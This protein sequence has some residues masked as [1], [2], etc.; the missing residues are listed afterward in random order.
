MILQALA[1]HY[2]RLVALGEGDA[3]GTAPRVAPFG[4][5]LQKVSFAVVVRPDGSL[6]QIESRM[7]ESGGGGKSKGKPRPS[8]RIVPGQAKP[9]GSGLNP[10]FLWD[11]PAYLLGVP[12]DP[13]DA[14][15]AARAADGF[16][17]L[18][19]RHLALE[20]AIGDDAFSAVCRFLRAWSPSDAAGAPGRENLDGPGFGVFRL[21]GERRDVHER[22]AVRAYWKSTLTADGDAA[23]GDDGPSVGTCLITGERAKLARLHEPKIKGVLG[24]QSSGGAIVS[25]NDNAYES[26]GHEQGLN[27]PTSEAAAFAYCTALNALLADERSRIRLGDTTCVA[28]SDAPEEKLTPIASGLMNDFVFAQDKSGY[29]DDSPTAEQ[30]RKAVTGFLH[31]LRQGL[32][33]DRAAELEDSGHRFYL[34]GLAPNAARISVRFFHRSTAGAFAENLAD[35]AQNLEMVG[36][37]DDDRPLTVQAMLRETVRDAKDVQPRLEGDV[38]RAVV[39]GLPY[40][41]TLLTRLLS[42]I[43]LDGDVSPDRA[44]ILRAFLLRNTTEIMDVYLNRLHPSRAYHCG[45]QFAVL[46]FAQERALPNVKAGVVKR[47]FAAAMARP[48]LTLGRLQR[49]TEVAHFPKLKGDLEQFARDELQAISGRLGDGPP[50]IL[51]FEDQ[52][53]FAL[54]YYQQRAHLDA[55]GAQVAQQRRYRSVQGEWMRSRLETKV[56]ADLVRFGVPYVYEPSALLDGMGERWPDFLLPGPTPEDCVY[57]E[58]AGYPGEAYD[59]RH[60]AKVAAY[61]R[62]GI[63]PDG[64]PNGR[65][66]VI[67]VRDDNSRYDS[68]LFRRHLGFLL[69][70]AAAA[71]PTDETPS[72]TSPDA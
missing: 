27:A 33:A 34:L 64:G 14:K 8:E 30:T 59:E 41:L 10:C 35:H 37:R 69:H 31:R 42:R 44:G 11:N 12:A 24:G 71:S 52:T 4:S 46:A 5:S 40:P 18:R 16:A 39:Q 13:G 55:A 23:D 25:F 28:W 53:L 48:G 61:G 72:E 15:K 36:R 70:T 29:L 9:P 1:E 58:V 19:D 38:L 68:D 51:G 50:G 62:S 32:P 2:D 66:V 26:H 57:L 3:A 20:E 67:D 7:Q 60:K 54:G 21:D 43:R 47:N 56:A 65:L 45:R 17:A 49:N 6:V 63:E 22:P